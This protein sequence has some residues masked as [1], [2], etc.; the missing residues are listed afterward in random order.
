[1]SN[2]KNIDEVLAGYGA[3]RAD[4]YHKGNGSYPNNE[5]ELLKAQAKQNLSKLIEGVM[6]ERLVLH[7]SPEPRAPWRGGYNQAIDDITQALKSIG[8]DVGG[9]DEK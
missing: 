9:G 2:P 4:A 7:E 5:G 3:E 8:L 6:P 1:M